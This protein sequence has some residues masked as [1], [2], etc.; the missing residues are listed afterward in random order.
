MAKGEKKGKNS[1]TEVTQPKG[2]RVLA[3]FASQKSTGSEKSC[4]ENCGKVDTS[5]NQGDNE[6][7]PSKEGTPRG[8]KRFVSKAKGEVS[9]GGIWTQNLEE[10]TKENEKK[11]PSNIKEAREKQLN[12]KGKKESLERYWIQNALNEIH[13]LGFREG[14][15]D[16]G[17]S[18]FQNWGSQRRTKREDK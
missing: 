4:V 6:M 15:I 12:R 8:V 1:F 13:G 14:K 16:R 5:L 2:R 11:T 9:K 10:Y 3:E 17:Q 18:L 7:S